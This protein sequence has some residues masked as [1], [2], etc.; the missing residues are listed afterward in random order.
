VVVVA[1]CGNVRVGGAEEA[2][3]W[4]RCGCHVVT[5]YV[6]QRMP[7]FACQQVPPARYGRPPV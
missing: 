3:A 1:R 5:R 4:S 7:E 2:A 6:Q